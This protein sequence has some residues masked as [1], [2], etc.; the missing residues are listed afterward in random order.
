MKQCGRC[1][2]T[3]KSQKSIERSFGPS[4]YKKHLQALAQEWIEKNQITIFEVM[5]DESDRA[6]QVC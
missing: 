1:N 2:R 4:C 5:G 3:L 6:Q